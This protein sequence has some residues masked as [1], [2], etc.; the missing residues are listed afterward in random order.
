VFDLIRENNLF[1]DVQD[2]ILLLV[3][4]DHELMEKRKQEGWGGNEVKSD[5]INLLVNNIHSI[6]VRFRFLFF[7]VEPYLAHFF[8]SN[9]TVDYTGGATASRAIVLSFPLPGCPCA[10]RFSTCFWLCGF[11]CNEF[12]SP[13]EAFLF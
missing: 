8:F 3:E 4:F 11:A 10:Y 5:A 12:L 2:Q 9:E 6:P 7:Y 1:T 13:T